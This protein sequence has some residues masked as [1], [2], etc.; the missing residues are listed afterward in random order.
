M[1]Q[2]KSG[3]CATNFPAADVEGKF[4]CNNGKFFEIC[5]GICGKNRKKM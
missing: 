2:W 4:S 1:F 3:A 5:I